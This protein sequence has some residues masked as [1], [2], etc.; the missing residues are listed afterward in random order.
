LFLHRDFTATENKGKM[1]KNKVQNYGSKGLV[2]N[3]G[4]FLVFA[5]GTIPMFST[6]A[7]R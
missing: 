4:M 6:A 3:L 1:P 7:P 2:Q 5:P